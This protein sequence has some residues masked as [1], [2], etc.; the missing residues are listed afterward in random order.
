MV[1]ELLNTPVAGGV[2]ENFEENRFL[3]RLYAHET[4]KCKWLE[5][6]SDSPPIDHY[7]YYFFL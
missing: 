3:K 5:E 4:R 2:N 1:V 7:Y 6:N